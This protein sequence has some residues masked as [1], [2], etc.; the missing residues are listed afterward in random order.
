VL[1]SDAGTLDRALDQPRQSG[2]SVDLDTTLAQARRLHPGD[3]V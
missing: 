2:R 1:V 3:R